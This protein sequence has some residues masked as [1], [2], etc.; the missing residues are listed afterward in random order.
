MTIDTG[1]QTVGLSERQHSKF[2]G[3]DMS[4]LQN[5]IE[6]NL[7]SVFYSL[8]V[9]L[10]RPREATNREVDM[11][12]FELTFE[13]DFSSDELDRTKWRSH[14]V[15]MRRGGYWA[16]EQSFIE[17]GML[18]IRTEYRSD[19]PNGA[20]WYS[21]GI[22]TSGLFEQTYG[23]FE[24]RCKLPAAQGLWSAFWLTRS[25]LASD[26]PGTEGTEIDVFESPMYNR[27]G[28]NKLITSNLHYNG[29]GAAHRFHNVGFFKVKNPYEEFNTY[30]L[31]WNEKEYIFYING[32]ETAR[33]SFG[34]VSRKDEYMLLSVEVD[35]VK[36]KPAGGWS[37]I[38]TKNKENA[39]P[40]DFVIDYVRAYR[41]K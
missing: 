16:P 27:K 12:K 40:S 15:G 26:K 13:D 39:M 20:G 35:G 32:R 22:C 8:F 33:S 30:G 23:Y 6:N 2:G 9:T 34:G 5:I 24:C 41:Y 11:S 3:N 37:G 14:H 4:V 18:H 21:D 25:G 1:E 10:R 36:G 28:D 19:G 38:V 7:M 31:E 17:D 29:Y